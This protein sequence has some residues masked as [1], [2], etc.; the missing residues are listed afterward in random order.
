MVVFA[1]IPA[2]S[3]DVPITKNWKF[4]TGDDSTTWQVPGFNDADWKTIE[5]GKS[6]EEQGYTDYNGF[7]WYRLHVVIP[8]SI[9]DKSYLKENLRINLGAIANGDEVYLNGK[10]VGKNGN[11]PGDIRAGRRGPRIYNVPLSDNTIM[12]DKDNVIAIRVWNNN[13]PGGLMAGDYGISMVDVIDFVTLNTDSSYVFS[14]KDKISKTLLLQSTY[15]Q[16]DYKGKLNISI[17]D[18]ETNKKIYSQSADAGFSKAK[19]FA[20]TFQ[21]SLPANKSYTVDYTFVEDKTKKQL[22]KTEGSPY[23]LTPLVSPKPRI[24][25]A[26]VF[27]ARPS[28]PFMYKIAATGDKPLQYAVKNLPAGLKVDAT[29]GIITGTVAKKGSYKVT[30]GVKNRLGSAEKA[31]TIEIG[32]LIGL[33]PALGWNSWNAWGLSVSDEKVRIS[34]KAMADHLVDH[35][36]TYINID[37]G[38]EAAARAANGEMIPNEKFPDMKALTGYVHGLGLKMGIYSSPGPKTCG[39]YLG[40]YEH[41][42][43]DAKMYGDWGIDYLKYD[44]CSYSQV[45][46]RNPGLD[47]LKKPY[48]VMRTALDKVNRDIMY[49]LCQYGWGDVWK[50]G[51][52]VGG[53]S[54]RTTGDI[55]DTWQSLSR[56]GFAQDKGSPY[57]AP[58]HFNDPDMMIVGKVGWGPRLHNSRL[59]PDEQYTHLSLWSLLAA[60]LLIGCDMGQLDNFTLN[61]LT[62]DEVL[63]IDQ[64]ALGK[65]AFKLLEKDSIQVWVKELKNGDKAVGIFNLANTTQKTTVNFADI[66]LTASLRLRDVWRQK[67]L[68]KFSNSYAADVPP[69]GVVYIRASGM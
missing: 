42:E 21:A 10:L 64:D 54:W 18:P 27:G 65:Q 28:N 35:G 66:K 6:W 61:L 45:A 5:A 26:D 23:L 3:Q 2:L 69:H 30:L 32:D 58:G 17:H 68:G 59:T 41:E 34:A 20:Y 31:F 57:A 33:T 36:W 52:E 13:G 14:G 1:F 24:N 16:Y 46:P 12:W 67:D 38:W 7:A 29:T 44:W 40:T 55:T 8:S 43:Q 22:D 49:S 4:K 51:A 11:R 25:G 48:T 39:G 47:E 37:D 56:I 62:N 15:E 19:P 63:A 50:W 9:K 60:P 53:N